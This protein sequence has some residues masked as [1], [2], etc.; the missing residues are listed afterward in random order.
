M[1]LPKFCKMPAAFCVL[2]ILVL[3]I[4]NVLVQYSP[5]I[6]Q[7]SRER[8]IVAHFDSYW[9]KE[10]AKV[11]RD[12][13]VEPTEKIYREELESYLKKYRE[14]NPPLVPEERIAKMKDDFR[15]WWETGGKNSYVANKQSPDEKLYQSEL[16]RYIKGYTKDL[17]LYNIAYVPEDS[18]VGAVFTCWTLT[19]GI[20]SFVLFAAGLLLSVQ[21]LSK[22]WGALQTSILWVA[23]ILVGGFAFVGTLSLSYFTRYST[24]PFMGASIALALMLGMTAF[25]PKRETSRKVSAVAIVIAA[26]DVLVNWNLNPNLYGW[27]AI[28]EVPFFG[29]GALAGIKLPRLTEQGKAARREEA[30]NVVRRD[31]KEV[32]RE[33][34]KDAA[35]LA[36][37]AEYDH[38]AK[39]YTEKFGLLL[40][41][42]PIDAPTVEEVLD[43]LLYPRFF[44]PIPGMQWLA[45][46]NE[47]EKKGLTKAAIALY[48]KGLNTELDARTRR[49]GLFYVGSL[50]IKT[51]NDAEKGRAEL[52]EAI[53]I[54]SSDILAAE[55][56]KL[57]GK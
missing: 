56:R 51:S 32:L 20:V 49:R 28:L 3:G 55:A 33:N 12:V 35:D 17:P 15:A 42:N 7:W 39:I 29:L 1:S 54:E 8:K 45:W 21:V 4:E 11:F 25:G 22:R 43:S 37:K 27:A 47:A 14:A 18:S 34:L 50:R 24:T 38:A 36:N 48:E 9:E 13:G 26:I 19:P 23:G 44:F 31:Q 52:E 2:L 41:E 5:K 57:L 40:K 6:K 10:G 16:K 30:G 46:A 53:A